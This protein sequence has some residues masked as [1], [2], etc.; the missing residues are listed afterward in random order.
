[1]TREW[2]R[3]N[4]FV[5]LLPFTGSSRGDLSCCTVLDQLKE[6]MAQTR[7]YLL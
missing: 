5:L 2:P 4:N 7:V 6:T 1:M 3:R